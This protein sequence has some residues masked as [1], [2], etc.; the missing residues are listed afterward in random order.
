MGGIDEFIEYDLQMK[1]S[2]YVNHPSNLPQ[3]P[4][5]QSLVRQKFRLPD[6]ESTIVQLDAPEVLVTDESI[7]NIPVSVREEEVQATPVEGTSVGQ[8]PIDIES[9]EGRQYV[10]RTYTFKNST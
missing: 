7:S 5:V 1:K 2:A 8:V 3:A 4:A 10:P 9:D 6:V